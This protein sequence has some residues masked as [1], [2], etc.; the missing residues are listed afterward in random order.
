MDF[1]YEGIILRRADPDDT[2]QIINL[3]EIGKDDAYNRVYS[4]PRILKLIESAYLAISVL[5]REGN[6]VAFAAF[7]DYPQGMRGMIDDK[8]FNLWEHWFHKALSSTDLNALNTL[9]LSYFVAGGSIS[10]KDQ[11]HPFKKILQTVYSSTPEVI[12]ILFLSSKCIRFCFKFIWGL[13]SCV[14]HVIWALPRYFHTYTTQPL[15]Q[16]L[17]HKLF[18]LPQ[19]L[20]NAFF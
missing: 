2:D 11:H 20:T 12:G 6:V 1:D 3:Q 4:Y 15:L 14:W 9:W 10:Y 7:E 8:H 18:F 5:D 13:A 19:F 17:F 16:L